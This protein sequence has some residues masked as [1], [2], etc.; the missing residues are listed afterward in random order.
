M[1]A[2]IYMLRLELAI[3]TLDAANKAANNRH[4]LST[5][6]IAR[7]VAEEAWASWITRLIGLVEVPTG[8]L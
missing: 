6:H 1:L 4:L 2:E 5:P 3:R 8:R 7:E